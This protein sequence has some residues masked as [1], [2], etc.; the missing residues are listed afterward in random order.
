MPQGERLEFADLR[1]AEIPRRGIVD[2]FALIGGLAGLR[3]REIAQTDVLGN[4]RCLRIMSAGGEI[5]V[6][7][8]ET[9]R[10][11]DRAQPVLRQL[12]FRPSK[13]AHLRWIEQCAFNP[14][15]SS[16]AASF[17]A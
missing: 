17:R 2:D 4:A 14:S 16:S 3:D 6:K 5:L 11:E 9:A 8:V 13:P 10:D 15:R 12:P 7:R 1:F